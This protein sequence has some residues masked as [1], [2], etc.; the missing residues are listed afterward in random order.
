LTAIQHS[1]ESEES[2]SNSKAVIAPQSNQISLQLPKSSKNLERTYQPKASKLNA[3]RALDESLSSQ[4]DS[5][6][7]DDMLIVQ[8]LRE[9][10][11]IRTS[12]N[13]NVIASIKQKPGE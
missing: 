5:S 9:G 13:K 7:D 10:M 8:N 11:G 6:F 4:L 1:F 12:H 3:N 2:G